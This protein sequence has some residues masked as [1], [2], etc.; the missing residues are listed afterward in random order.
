[1]V[2][3]CKKETD[4]YTHFWYDAVTKELI[5]PIII[6][7]QHEIKKIPWHPRSIIFDM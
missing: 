2:K 6:T 7:V 4:R 5:E 1:M 3:G